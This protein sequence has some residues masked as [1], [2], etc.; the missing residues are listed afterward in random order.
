MIP[1]AAPETEGREVEKLLI[2]GGYRKMAR[3]CL[4]AFGFSPQGAE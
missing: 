1:V 4:Y 3:K 2:T